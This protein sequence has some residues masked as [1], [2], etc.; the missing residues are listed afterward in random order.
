MTSAPR[1]LRSSAIPD[2]VYARPAADL[3]ETPA[4]AIEVSP[5][6]PGAAALEQQP[7]ES[8]DSLTMLAP[9]GVLE[10]RYALALALR[11]L[12]PGGRLT[13]LAA[14]D[15]GGARMAKEL[16]GFGCVVTETARRHH[17]FCHTSRPDDP[18][19]LA[20]AIAAGAPR[21]APNLGLWSQPGVFSWDRPDPGSRLLLANLPTLSGVG[22][23]LGCGIGLLALKVLE[24]PAV[25]ALHLIDS[26]RRA[27]EAARR[28][29][30][31]PRARF[32]W[33]DVRIE[34]PELAG[35]DFVVMNPPFHD[36]GQEDR[37]LGGAFI[38]RAAAMLRPKGVC[39][40][41]ANRHLP[42]EALLQPL[43]PKARQVVQAE[44]YKI[45]EARR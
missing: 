14:K 4:A 18:A 36:Q 27:I 38:Q 17:R 15:K 6:V 8:F 19:G 43:F 40:L 41:V 1:F 37:G 24:S 29:V 21:I 3:I 13:A 31:D 22:A 10:R 28:N 11:V 32:A 26:D 5:L 35:F 44:G 23:D 45:Y 7:D 20:E 33:R 2:A 16:A 42:Y 34:S 12:K 30:G 39:W 25:T 9:P